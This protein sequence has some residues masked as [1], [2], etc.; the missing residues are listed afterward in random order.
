MSVEPARARLKHGLRLTEPP[1]FLS[2]SLE[3][4]L[5]G[6]GY[7]R[8][9]LPRSDFQIERKEIQIGHKEIKA[10]HKEFQIIRNEIQMQ[11]PYFSKA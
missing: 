10:G 7:R 5:A 6:R 4:A 2:Q 1:P 8:W 9:P 3:A 11:R